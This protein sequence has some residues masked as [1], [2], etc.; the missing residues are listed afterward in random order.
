MAVLDGKQKQGVLI[1]IVLDSNDEYQGYG[2]STNSTSF[3]NIG[4]FTFTPGSSGDYLIFCHGN[5]DVDNTACIATIE[6]YDNGTSTSYGTS[7]L[8]P[9]ATTDRRPWCTMFKLTLAAS[10]QTFYVR[11]KVNSA[12]YTA[13]ITDTSYIWAL[14]LDQFANAYYAESRGQ[15][16]STS[17][18]T[19]TDKV[20]LTQTPAAGEHLIIG[21]AL[22]WNGAQTNAVHGQFEDGGSEV[23]EL[24][25]EPNAASGNDK[26][27]IVWFNKNYFAASSH[28]WK[29]K[30][31]KYR[32]G[33]GVANMSEAAIAVLDLERDDHTVKINGGAIKGGAIL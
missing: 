5:L 16:T 21:T 13:S 30:F 12:S 15:T 10:S 11:L 19:Y 28:T 31:K 27:P 33:L 14:R 4:T 20:T 8:K 32:S 6:V 23:K 26:T 24:I 2:G 25:F 17:N 1:G 18:T 7:I 3:V 22:C 29:L 9:I